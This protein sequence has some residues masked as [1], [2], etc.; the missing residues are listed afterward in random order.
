[1]KEKFCKITV[2]CSVCNYEVDVEEVT[3][4]PY[5]KMICKDCKESIKNGKNGKN[6]ENS[7][8]EKNE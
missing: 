8:R 1:M 5:G 2:G 4:T 6:G 7:E 3:V